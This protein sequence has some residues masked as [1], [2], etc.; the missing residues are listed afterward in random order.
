MK[1]VHTCGQ[2]CDV[3]APLNTSQA[4]TAHV[5]F[6]FGA[7]L[8]RKVR[9]LLVIQAPD[10]TVVEVV[11]RQVNFREFLRRGHIGKDRRHVQEPTHTNGR[12]IP[13]NN[14]GC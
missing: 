12:E 1:C 4:D 14:L 11:V 2:L 13:R 10:L 6:L 9:E 3:L 5:I 7:D 8:D